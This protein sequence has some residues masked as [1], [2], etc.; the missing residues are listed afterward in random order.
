ML[1]GEK[2]NKRKEKKQKGKKGNKRKKERKINLK[3]KRARK[4]SKQREN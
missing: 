2:E 3:V 1:R 4:I